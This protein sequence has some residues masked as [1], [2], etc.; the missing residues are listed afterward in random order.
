MVRS[1]CYLLPAAIGD[2]TVSLLATALTA[3]PSESWQRVTKKEN[4]AMSND[5]AP[6]AN[7][8]EIP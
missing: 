6:A 4:M 5:L 7:R 3:L 8:D 2:L 1:A